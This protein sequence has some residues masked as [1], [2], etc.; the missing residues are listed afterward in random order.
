MIASSTIV[1]TGAA[2]SLGAAIALQL[3]SL[4]PEQYHLVLAARNTSSENAARL[5]KQLKAAGASFQWENLDLLSFDSIIAFTRRLEAATKADQLPAII[6]LVNSAAIAQIPSEN[7][8]DGFDTIY[9]TNVLSPLFLM[10]QLLSLFKDGGITINVSTAAITLGD[11][12]YFRNK[13]EKDLGRD[14]GVQESLKKYGSSKL[15]LLMAGYAL[16]RSKPQFVC[17]HSPQLC[18]ISLTITAV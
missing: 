16:Q 4:F 1:I 10:H 11:I 13:S 15:L 3:T 12:Q 2:G 8:K 17:T 9:Q 14:P 18:C 6:G 7:S 5:T